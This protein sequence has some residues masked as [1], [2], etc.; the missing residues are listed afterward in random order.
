MTDGLPLDDLSIVPIRLPHPS[1]PLSMPIVAKLIG[2][3]RLR[4]LEARRPPFK[5]AV[6]AA[7][8]IK[9]SDWF[10]RLKELNPKL[11]HVHFGTNA[12]EAWPLAIALK[13]PMVVTLQGYDASIHDTWW[14]SGQGGQN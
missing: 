3:K 14:E 4:R 10:P 7:K 13:I 6:A 2:R 12:E 8:L 11:L 5:R 9:K 1:D